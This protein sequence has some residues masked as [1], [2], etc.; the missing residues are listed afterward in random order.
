MPN[1]VGKHNTYIWSK[2]HIK[3]EIKIAQTFICTP[4]MYYEENATEVKIGSRLTL[5]Y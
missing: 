4:K 5:T 3:Y 2:C 1:K